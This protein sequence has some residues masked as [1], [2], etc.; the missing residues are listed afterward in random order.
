[1]TTWAQASAELGNVTPATRE[2]ARRVFEAAAAAGHDIW[3]LWGWGPLPE[4]NSR[5]AID[6][7]VKTRAAGAWV[8]THIWDY[9]D[10]YGL[11]HVIWWQ[12]ITSTVTQPGVERLMEDRGDDTANHRD[13]V[14]ALRFDV[15][16]RSS[17]PPAPVEGEDMGPKTV[18]ARVKGK[19]TVW[20]KEPG[21]DWRPLAF[22][23]AVTAWV[24]AGAVE[25]PEAPDAHAIVDAFGPT[26]RAAATAAIVA[27]GQAG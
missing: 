19:K 4:H 22:P 17:A 15:P 5:C 20:L 18:L 23:W 6:F 9:R 1:M 10:D 12:H 27:I 3:F 25:L 8:R 16:L 21:E 11:R 24:A 14:H 13:H 7:M 2:F 26:S